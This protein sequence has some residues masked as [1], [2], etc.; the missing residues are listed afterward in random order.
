MLTVPTDAMRLV[1]ERY[2][3]DLR[4]LSDP[5][6]TLKSEGFFKSN[7]VTSFVTAKTQWGT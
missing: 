5:G 4:V 2:Q 7:K 1:M 3:N 6:K